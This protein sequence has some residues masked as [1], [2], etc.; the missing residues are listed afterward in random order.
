MLDEKKKAR[1]SK[2]P[3]RKWEKSEY[4]STLECLLRVEKKG[5]KKGIGE[6]MHDL[7]VEKGM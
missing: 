4:I 5:V 3:R 7:W 1:T 6:L 2:N